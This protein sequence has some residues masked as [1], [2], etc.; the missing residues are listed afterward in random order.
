MFL[1]IVIQTLMTGTD[2]HA[3]MVGI[4]QMK[5]M[6]TAVIVLTDTQAKTVLSVRKKNI[7]R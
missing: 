6:I 5:S 7:Y 1:F 2:N 3:R 4:V